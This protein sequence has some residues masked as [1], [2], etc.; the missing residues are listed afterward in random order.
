[1]DP[2]AFARG[3][4]DID[5]TTGREGEA[6]RWLAQQSARARLRGHRT[7]RRWR[8]LQRH[9]DGRPTGSGARCGPVHAL[10]L[11]AAVFSEPPGRRSPLR[12]RIVRREGHSGRAGGGGWTGCRR[13]GETR[14]GLCLSSARSAAAMARSWRTDV[15]RGHA[16]PGQRRADREPPRSRD[17]RHPQAEAARCRPRGSFVVSGARRVG[18]RQVARRARRVAD[19]ARCRRIGVSAERHYTIGLISGGVA[20][21]V[22]SPSAE[23]EVMFRTVGDGAEVRRR[24]RRSS[25]ACRSS[26]CS[27]CRRSG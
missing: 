3:L 2:V 10:R 27:K 16:V 24:S 15:A 19:D 18:D 14:V 5:S 17:A 25:R 23:A 12:P 13:D 26:T 6:G 9:R 11:R 8:A 7:A 20:P 1:M 22:V 21:N 4:I